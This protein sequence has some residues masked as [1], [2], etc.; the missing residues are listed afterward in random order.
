[1][2]SGAIYTIGHSNHSLERFLELLERFQIEVLVDV[3]TN[4]FAR[5]ARHF[6]QDPLKIAMQG[7]GVKYL[8]LGKELGG[9]PKDPQFYDDEGFV[10]YRL[11]SQSEAFAEGI[12][13]LVNGIQLYR[14][15]IM[16]AE[17]SP[18]DCHRR[19]LIGRVLF[20]RGIELKHI[21]S[22]GELQLESEFRVDEK[23]ALEKSM[24]LTL[25]ADLEPETPW[26]SPH[27]AKR[28]N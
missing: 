3:R 8:F 24:Q 12:D 9:K 19:L 6:S 23:H 26:R 4:P 13:R 1:M 15:A 10:D 7:A 17:E 22:S 27:P 28:K 25:F 2:S 5:F 20:S 18:I 21:R 11:V 16:C 14:V